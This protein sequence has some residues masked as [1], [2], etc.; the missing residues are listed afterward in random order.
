MKKTSG[1]LK[2]TILAVSIIIS[3]GNPFLFAAQDAAPLEQL[4]FA[5]GLFQRG[6]YQMAIDEYKRF[7][8]SFPQSEYL[9]DA[10]FGIAE[11]HYFLKE[12]DTAIKEYNQYMGK[13]PSGDKALTAEL[14]IGEAFFFTER[15]DDAIKQFQF[16]KKEG[17]GKGKLQALYFYTG[18]AYRAKGNIEKAIELLNMAV[19]TADKGEYT[20]HS[21]ICMLGAPLMEGH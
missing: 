3:S 17:L 18:K 8:D 5:T 6:M 11:S 12:Y 19:G 7:I 2:A 16:I 10:Y 20:F 1:V 13:F 15:L 21:F 9:E 14:R 4:D